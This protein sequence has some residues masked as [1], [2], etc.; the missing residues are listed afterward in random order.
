MFFNGLRLSTIVSILLL[1]L[2]LLVINRMNQGDSDIPPE[3]SLVVP[4]ENLYLDSPTVDKLAT[5]RNATAVVLK[6][7][8]VIGSANVIRHTKNEPI[9]LLTAWHVVDGMYPDTVFI[10]LIDSQTIKTVKVVKFNKEWDIALL[11]GTLKESSDGPAVVLSDQDPRLGEDV[12]VIGHPTGIVGNI[13]R[14]VVGSILT[15]ASGQRILRIDAAVYYGNSGGGIYNQAGEFVGLVFALEQRR[16]NP[17]SSE[18]VPGGGI[19]LSTK[20]VHQFLRK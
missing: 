19:G 11:E 8:R 12:W 20:S 15:L 16:Q 14:G 17:F 2:A 3:S 1:S 7:G 13:T 6:D 5:Q 4:Y 10:G 18:I 9:Q